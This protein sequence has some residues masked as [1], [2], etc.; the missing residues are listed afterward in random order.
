[1]RV[2]GNLVIV[3]QIRDV[4][5]DNLVSDPGTPVE[6]RIWYNTTEKVYKYYDGTTTHILATGGGDLSAYLKHDGS[7]AMSGELT[8]NSTDQS[9][10]AGTVAVSKG[11]LDTTLATKQDNL[12]GAT[13]NL[14]STNLSNNKAVV[15][16]G[17][18]KI[19]SATNATAAEIEYLAG[20]TSAIQSQLDSKE[21]SLGYTPL[22][23]DGDFM[24]GNLAMNGNTITGLPAAVDQTDAV[25][26]AD[27]QAAIVG[28][29]IQSD[30][31]GVQGGTHGD[32]NLDP[33][34]TPTEGDRY[35][36]NNVAALH[37]NFG[38]IT[39]VGD[40]DIV[41]YRSGAFV[42]T[43]D[44]SEQGAGALAWNSE[45]GHEHFEYYNGTAWTEFG[46]LSGVTAGNGL[47]KTGNTLDINMGAGVTQLPSDEV[48]LDLRA[49]GG[50][51]LSTD[52]STPSTDTAAQLSV[53]A[54]DGITVGAGGVAVAANGIVESMLNTSVAGDG[55]QGGGGAK[56]SI[57]ALANG[58]LTVDATGIYVDNT[59]M[60]TRVL[61]RDG[62]E[63]MTGP[64]VL[65]SSD[66]TGAS[67]AT[68]VSKGH[69]DAE[70]TTLNNAIS[71]LETSVG[72]GYFLYEETVTPS[73]TH[74]VTH[75]MGT[76]YVGVT[77]IDS[78]G[79]VVIPQ[80]ISYTDANSLTV[81]FSSAETCRVVVN[82]L[83]V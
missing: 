23:K 6:S 42:V 79:E 46:G 25:R 53:I 1:M 66:Q 4:K 17:N 24:N 28:L 73:T 60:R 44:V 27:L 61:Y 8:L 36:V 38:T 81:T 5:I 71:A 63:A 70:I 2:N 26:L 11:Y 54:G 56:L 55:L 64:L 75:N 15:S 49:N 31:M 3:G 43:Y 41:E 72:A 69:L 14:T 32:D 45:V 78:S 50:L 83:K 22:N 30:V 40:G 12:T 58:G 68:A 37:A 18:G 65:S 29:D 77:V 39:G 19:I 82:G 34:A 9:A 62:A 35:I 48:G 51:L 33:G 74:T 13:S 59:E 76:Q 20:V 7:I 21:G 52:G 57:V 67:A 16:D 10:S 47:S 80:S